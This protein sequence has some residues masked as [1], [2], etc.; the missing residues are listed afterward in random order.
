MIDSTGMT[1]IIIFTVGLGAAMAVGDL[2]AKIELKIGNSLLI[3]AT[4]LIITILIMFLVIYPW[5]FSI[6]E[7]LQL[8]KVQVDIIITVVVMSFGP[9]T[10]WFFNWWIKYYEKKSDG[11]RRETK[12]IHADGVDLLDQ[13]INETIQDIENMMDTCMISGRAGIKQDNNEML[14]NIKQKINSSLQQISDKHDRILDDIIKTSSKVDELIS[15]ISKIDT[16]D[17]KISQIRSDIKRIDTSITTIADCVVPDDESFDDK[18]TE[19]ALLPKETLRNKKEQQIQAL[20]RK[21]EEYKFVPKRAQNKAEPDISLFDKDEKLQ[22]TMSVKVRS[23]SDEAGNRSKRISEKKCIVALKHAEKHGV[24]F[25]LCVP[26]TENGRIW[27]HIVQAEQV[28][29]WK[30]ITTLNILAQNDETTLQTLEEHNR[31]VITKLGGFT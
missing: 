14:Q 6:V 18:A 23:I 17:D 5:I 8:D 2:K 19:S 12:K 9:P 7:P 11:T 29:D 28:K 27:F 20:C 24:P 3:Y 22:A 1:A 30:G 10:W 15:H 21:L 31:E 25:V 4:P 13:K 16:F 26:N